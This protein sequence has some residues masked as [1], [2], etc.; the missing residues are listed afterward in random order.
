MNPNVVDLVDALDD[1]ALFQ[2][3]FAGDTY[4]VW[5]ALFKA[6][7]GKALSAAELELFHS[8]AGERD[9]PTSPVR[10]L[11]VAAGRRAG[12]DSAAS[13]IV[14]AAALQDYSAIL[15]PG[16][17][18][19]VLCLAVDRGQAGIVYGYVRAFFQNILM[20]NAMV[21]SETALGLSLNNGVDIIIATNSFRAVR[22]RTIVAAVFDECSFWRDESSAHPDIETYRAVMPGMATVPNAL[23]IGISSPYRKAGLLYAK[24]KKHFGQNDAKTLYVKG[25]SRLFNPTIPQKEVDAAIAED[26]ESASAEWLG[27]FRSDLADFVTRESIEACVVTGLTVRPPRTGV[28]FFGAVDPSGGSNDA[29]T[30]AICSRQG[31]RIVL[32]CI[33]ERR[34]PFAPDSVVDEFA[35][36][37]KEYK[38]STIQGD[39]YAGEWPRE[40]FRT[41][42]IEYVVADMNRSELY[43]AMLPLINSGRVDLLDNSRM[44]AQFVG[45]ER[46]TARSGR[47]TVDHAPNSHD[48]VAN[49]CALAVAMAVAG[50]STFVTNQRMLEA[51]SRMRLPRGGSLYPKAFF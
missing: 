7:F 37:F 50:A 31:Q 32:D 6:A 14:T 8:I 16:E 39:A 49:V 10:E 25:P 43:L 47:D 38:I 13:A 20:L 34:A 28:T 22:G 24:F 41:R 12:K 19:V 9:P 21:T 4:D 1:P 18:A 29:M 5:K 42:G 51:A 40:R 11:W 35:A 48:D 44:I 27:E 30:M 3:W 17:R 36:V 2:P 46:R 33:G 23:L 45:L 26:P 15:R